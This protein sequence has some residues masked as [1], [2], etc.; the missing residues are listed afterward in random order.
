MDLYQPIL[1]IIGWVAGMRIDDGK[2]VPE[3]FEYSPYMADLRTLTQNSWDAWTCSS[4][5]SGMMNTY[6]F[7]EWMVGALANPK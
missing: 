6:P 3:S 1:P 7:A 5:N 2:N 4:I